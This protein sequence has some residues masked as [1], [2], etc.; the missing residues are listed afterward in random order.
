MQYFIGC[1]LLGAGFVC[2]TDHK[3]WPWFSIALLG[4]AIYLILDSIVD[5]KIKELRKKLNDIYDEVSENNRS[6]TWR[7]LMDL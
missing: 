6:S 5:D 4:G 3:I 7:E 1:L 2:L